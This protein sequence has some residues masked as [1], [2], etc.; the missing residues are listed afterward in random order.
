MKTK[1]IVGCLVVVGLLA[2]CFSSSVMATLIPYQYPGTA[3][4][5]VYTFVAAGGDVT[6]YFY[7]TDAAYASKIGLL[8][9]NTTTGR[10]G[11]W[12]HTSTV[13]DT[14]ILA[15][16]S[17]GEVNAGDI[18]VLRL[19]VQ[20]LNQYWTSAP[21]LNSD[22]LNHIY[23]TPFAANNLIPSGIYVGFEDLP[24]LGDKDYN[25]HQFVFTGVQ[26]PDGGTTCFLLGLGLAGLGLIKRK[27]A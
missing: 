6:A 23:A 26:V 20:N 1:Q 11:L 7:G 21:A 16:A 3:N 10:E 19:W 5:D 9:Q 4:P 2:F 13:G 22:G 17:L 8:V 27:L 15:D 18:L 14:L 12:N 24:G 25:D